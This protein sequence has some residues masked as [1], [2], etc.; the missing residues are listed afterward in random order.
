MECQEYEL[1]ACAV[2]AIIVTP[3][4]YCE[5]G[6]G[7]FLFSLYVHVKCQYVL[8]KHLILI[9]NERGSPQEA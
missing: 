1:R 6:T 4:K 8:M 2:C 7:L 5:G 9:I 3:L